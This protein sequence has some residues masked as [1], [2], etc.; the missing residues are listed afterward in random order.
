[1][2]YCLYYQSKLILQIECETIHI[3][4]NEINKM[5]K[6][7]I[8][9]N[10]IDNFSK[11]DFNKIFTTKRKQYNGFEYHIYNDKKD[12]KKFVSG[13]YEQTKQTKQKLESY[14]YFYV[15]DCE[16]T[17]IDGNTSLC[18]LYGF[19]RFDFSMNVTDENIDKLAH[20][21][22]GFQ[23]S[24]KFAN[25]LD[26]LNLKAKID[27]KKL[28][29]Y[30]HNLIYDL[31]ELIQNVIPKMHISDYEINKCYNDSIYRGSASKPLVFRLGNLFLIDSYALTN[32]SLARISQS[33]S[34]KKQIE[35][36]TYNE[37]FFFQ[38]NLPETEITYN[39]Y[40]LLVTALGVFDSIKACKQ[41][42]KTFN[43][44]ISQNVNTIT[45]LSKFLN[46]NIYEDKN[47][48]NQLVI[49]HK[50]NATNNLP[51][52]D[53]K[54]IDKERLLFYQNCFI[55]GYTHC[56]PF[57]A[58]RIIENTVISNDNKSDYPFQMLTR[59]FPYNFKTIKN[60]LL[61]ELLHYHNEN[62]DRCK[63]FTSSNLNYKFNSMSHFKVHKHYFL[64]YV[65][66][67]NVNIKIFDNYNIMAC[68]PV[69]K[70][71]LTNV[72][73]I[74][75]NNF[76]IDNGKI[77]KAL[78]PFKLYV[79]DIDLHCYSMF[80]DFNII[81]CDILEHTC[82]VHFLD[83][84]I[85]NSLRY[86]LTVKD[87]LSKVIKGNILL[88]N[89]TD[90]DGNKLYNDNI[91]ESF[92]K[93]EKLERERFLDFE[94]MSCKMNGINNQY[95]IN[96]QKIVND[97]IRFNLKKYQF[98]KNKDILQGCN[99]KSTTRDFISGLY[100][101][102]YARLTLSLITYMIYTETD[103][104]CV[105]WDTDSVKTIVKN[106]EQ[107]EQL[108]RVIKKY[109]S[110]IEKVQKYI[111]NRFGNMFGL[112]IFE[113]DFTYNEFFS[114][115]A[116]KYLTR[117]DNRIHIT[118]SGINKHLF[119]DFLTKKYK[120]G[121]NFKQLINNYYHPNVI[122]SY[123]IIKHLVIKYPS[124]HKSKVNKTF[125]DDN[126]KKC[127]VSQFTSPINLQ[128]SYDVMNI[129]NKLMN[130]LYYQFTQDL[131]GLA[132]FN[133]NNLNTNINFIKKEYKNDKKINRNLKELS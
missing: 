80:Y 30:V 119:S 125:I 93:M 17:S 67:S 37:K 48:N 123:D 100:I 52:T 63:D 102:A 39:K 1:M 105:Y 8:N 55:G 20:E 84:Y 86:H 51:F 23:S 77:I 87:S 5:L 127:R 122:L 74:D 13:N 42:F 98:I 75:T 16:T 121:L 59:L 124:Y 2:F 7:F 96:V 66:L 128:D 117:I 106:M 95:G 64:A 11:A 61:N 115:G 83:T 58:F 112:G 49:T 90:F 114:M 53:N 70:T 34:I 133:K 4:R 28:V 103:C 131:Q 132:G 76:I 31:Y 68:I 72:D 29:I 14:N 62:L 3:F 46:K 89:A 35:L 43:D 73:L 50:Q 26:K 120:N 126:G 36:K 69:S 47:K 110:A 79:T 10:S 116:K 101:T 57:Y 81:G 41:D 27:N 91:I 104:T 45:G 88:E 71:N 111:N 25:L 15:Y 40:D 118:N 19:Q 54:E 130:K 44:F 94:Y 33:H 109:N 97:E 56:N 129:D 9:A 85:Q 108:E 99:N 65:E 18:Y 21:Y 32:K 82:Q 38:S 113:N 78:K 24:K 60:N 22:Y 107:Q 92:Y 6:S 12:V